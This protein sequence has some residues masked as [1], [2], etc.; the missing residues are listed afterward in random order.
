MA[1]KPT[2]FIDQYQAFVRA[3]LETWS[4]QFDP[5]SQGSAASPS[6]DI[7][8]RMFTG[9]S[10]YGDWMRSMAAGEPGAAPFAMGGVPPFGQPGPADAFPPGAAPFGYGPP[11]GAAPYGYGPPPGAAMPPP[12]SESFDE[13]ARVAREALSM[14]AFGLTREQQEE[15]QDLFRAWIDYAEHYARFQALLQGVNDRAGAALREQP[16]PSDAESMRSVYDRWVNL[17][18]ESYGEAALSGEFRDVYAALVNAQMRLKVLQRKQVERV[19]GQAGMP[20]RSEVDSLG[21]RLQAMRRELR[22]M[23]GLVAEVEALRAEVA[24][25]RGG[26]TV[27]KKAGKPKVATRTTA[28]KGGAR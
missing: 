12:G 20:T 22:Q 17:A 9:L 23:H 25:L 2:D 24:S 5:A 16:A 7:M 28:K 4:R 3:G 26:K 11:P 18:E 21:E 13:W 19:T 27:A 8:G 14:P 1:D 15:Q 6:A 10:G